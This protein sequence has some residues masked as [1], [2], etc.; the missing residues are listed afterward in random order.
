MSPQQ[1]VSVRDL[2]AVG[3]AVSA[4]C[5]PPGTDADETDEADEA[6]CAAKP[7][8]EQGD[9][10]EQQHRG[11]HDRRRDQQRGRDGTTVG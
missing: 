1:D 2:L 11:Q 10:P 3:P 4:I 5:T 9:R 6:R 7:D 8:D